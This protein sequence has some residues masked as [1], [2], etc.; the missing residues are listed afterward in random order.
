MKGAGGG[1]NQELWEVTTAWNTPDRL[2]IYKFIYFFKSYESEAFDAPPPELLLLGKFSDKHDIP[3][4]LKTLV[5]LPSYLRFSQLQ[6]DTVMETL[7]FISGTF[8]E[9]VLGMVGPN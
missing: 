7:S 4:K 6:S 3:W 8:T 1:A 5:L 9:Q 2:Q